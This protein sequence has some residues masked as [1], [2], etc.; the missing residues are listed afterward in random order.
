MQIAVISDTHRHS[1]SINKAAS[2]IQGMDMVIHLGDNV[3]DVEVLKEKFK[4]NIIN[5]RGNCD[6]TSFVPRERLEEIEGK[7]IF[8]THGDKYNVKY[9]LLRLKYRAKEV[10]A[11]VVLFGHTHQSLELYE[12]GIWFIN[13]GSAALPRDSFKSI[14]VLEIKNNK[15]QVMLKGIE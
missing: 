2:I 12:D 9:D 10:G 8:M 1:Y 3:E 13:P 7:K 15:I 6:F 11:D 4:G 5:V 14:A